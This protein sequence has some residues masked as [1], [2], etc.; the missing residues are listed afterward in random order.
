M[1]FSRTFKTLNLD[2]QIQ[3][4][5]RCVR[6]LGLFKLTNHI[7]NLAIKFCDFKMDPM[8]WQL[9]F[10]SC[11]FGLKTCLWSVS[12]F[13]SRVWFQT[14]LHST[15]FN[16]HY[17]LDDTKSYY[18]LIIKII[19][20]EKRRIANGYER[21]GKFACRSEIDSNRNGFAGCQVTSEKEVLCQSKSQPCMK[22]AQGAELC[23]IWLKFRT[24]CQGSCFLQ[25]SRFL[26]WVVRQLT[27]SCKH[28][29]QSQWWFFVSLAFRDGD[30]LKL[31]VFF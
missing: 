7:A 28:Q 21:K 30:S 17:K 11:K 14:K 3:G 12:I 27:S 5:L 15:Q 23:R 13:K 16:Y 2:F 6:T 26:S 4:L 20:S 10:G 25:N 19:I 8:K 18:Q 31:L 1:S 24:L 22:N 9:N 29:S